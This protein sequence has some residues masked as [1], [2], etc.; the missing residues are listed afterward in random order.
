MNYIP[1]GL[2]RLVIQRAAVRCEYCRLSQ[3]G[4]EA[5][6]HTDHIIPVTAG[7]ATAAENLALACVSCSLRKSARQTAIDPQ[8]GAEVVLYNPRRDIWH[9]HLRWEG[10]YLVGLTASR[11]ATIEALNMNRLLIRAI[12]QEEIM[13]GR[14]PPP[15]TESKP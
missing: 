5:T 11:R 4:Q 13:R 2:R 10:V 15:D 3:E 6:F 8:S 9:E 1:V 14:H 7:G 12:R